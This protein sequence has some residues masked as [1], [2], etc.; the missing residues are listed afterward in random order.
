M[1]QVHMRGYVSCKPTN[2]HT[3]GNT[4]L[5][6]LAARGGGCNGRIV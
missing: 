1:S 3:G 4:H 2:T 5:L 6:Q